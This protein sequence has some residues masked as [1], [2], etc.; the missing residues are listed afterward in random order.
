M[1]DSGNFASNFFQQGMIS[2]DTTTSAGGNTTG[3]GGFDRGLGGPGS[4][5]G[6]GTPVQPLAKNG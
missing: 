6:T 5:Y 2:G 1:F 4:S 3:R